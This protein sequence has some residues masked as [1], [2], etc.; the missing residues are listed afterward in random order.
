[1]LVVIALKEFVLWVRVNFGTY[2][3]NFHMLGFRNLPLKRTYIYDIY[4]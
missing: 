3:V 1:M 2:T 4:G